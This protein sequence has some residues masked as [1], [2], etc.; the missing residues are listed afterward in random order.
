VGSGIEKNLNPG[1]EI[2]SPDPGQWYFRI[3]SAYR[4]LDFE[5]SFLWRYIL[6]QHSWLLCNLY[7]RYGTQRFVSV[8]ADNLKFD[9]VFSRIL[10]LVNALVNEWD[11]ITLG[12][13]DP[14]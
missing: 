13:S 14:E 2:N 4:R 10:I 11:K 1:S 5:Y 3:N 12:C 6:V 9:Y 7:G 8:P